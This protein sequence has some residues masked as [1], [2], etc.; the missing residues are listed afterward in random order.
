MTDD[1]P[2]RPEPIEWLIYAS[3][4][5]AA[6]QIEAAAKN[7]GLTA[8]LSVDFDSPEFATDDSVPFVPLGTCSGSVRMRSTTPRGFTPDPLVAAVVIRSLPGSK[9]TFE[10]A[11]S[12]N[13]WE[14][15]TLIKS[16]ELFVDAARTRLAVL[17][18]DVDDM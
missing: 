4:E 3:R 15:S 13:A 16:W 2:Y 12:R 10:A 6:T 5:Q 1:L 11:P 8:R 14:E 17:G 9:C 18:F 7:A